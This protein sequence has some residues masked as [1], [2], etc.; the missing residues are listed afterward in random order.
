M[1]IRNIGKKLEEKIRVKFNLPEKTYIHPS[2]GR[3]GM[4]PLPSEIPEPDVND[5]NSKMIEL[6]NNYFI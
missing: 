3:R 5:V 2:L 1:I 6:C 4:K